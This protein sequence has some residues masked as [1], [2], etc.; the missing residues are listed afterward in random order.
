[1]ELMNVVTWTVKD[2]KKDFHVLFYDKTRFIHL[3]FTN[4]LFWTDY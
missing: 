1:M 2:K 4:P 3:K